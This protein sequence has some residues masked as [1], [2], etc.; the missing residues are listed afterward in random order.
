M[1]RVNPPS[2]VHEALEASLK[3]GEF[4]RREVEISLEEKLKKLKWM[5]SL[6]ALNMSKVDALDS[7]KEFVSNF[8]KFAD[9]FFGG[10][11]SQVHIKK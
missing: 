5:E 7:A 3:S 2:L 11:G 10:R 4:G 8:G 1:W 6:Y 9:D